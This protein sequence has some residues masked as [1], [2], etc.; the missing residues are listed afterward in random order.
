MGR[1]REREIYQK[2]KN[3]LGYLKH[4]PCFKIKKIPESGE[5]KGFDC[6]INENVEAKLKLL[7]I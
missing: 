6:H 2:G 5:N 1:E 7:N 4:H 3:T